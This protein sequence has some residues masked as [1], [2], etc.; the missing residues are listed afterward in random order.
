MPLYICGK[1]IDGKDATNE[2]TFVMIEE[3]KAL[4]I[5]DPKIHVLYH[6]NIDKKI[7]LKV[8][9]SIR[10]GKSSFV[11][12]NVEMAE[13]ALINVGIN[14][15]DAKKLIVYGCYELAAEGTEIPPTC[16]GR[17]CMPKA[18]E[19]ALYDGFDYQLNKQVGLHTGSYFDSF[20][21]FLTAVKTQLKN[22]IQYCMDALTAYEKEYNEISPF[23]ILSAAFENCV[24]TAKDVYDGGA[25]YNN[26]SIN[27]FGMA[28][29]VD[30]LMV[31]KKLIFEEKKLSFNEFSEILKSNWK[32][33]ETLRRYCIKNYPKFGNNNTEADE[34]AVDLYNEVADY[35]NRKPNGRGGV[36]KHS[37]ISI[38]WIKFM[39]ARV[40][41]TP[42]GRFEKQPV[43][44]NLCA[45]V[46]QDKN[47]ITG[48]INS[49]L[50]LDAKKS[51]N[52]YVLDAVLHSS[53]AKGEE[54]L[55]ALYSLL[56]TYI[57][58]GG[59]AIH[60]NILDSK[61]LRKAQI[62]PAEYKNLQIRLCGWNVRFVDLDKQ[63]QDEF[64]LKTDNALNN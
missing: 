58:N 23:P 54:G 57:K 18:L 15:E 47:G 48:F 8:L 25:K 9:D 62:N 28:T 42:D 38:D 43:S 11:F 26:T 24:K 20:D 56:N 6:K 53:A 30:S 63:T 44:K 13:K 52:G 5:I 4:D 16:A 40:G 64:I 50:K 14:E 10:D 49:V 55:N 35:I 21:E 33:N 37:Q 31:I 41:A 36:F 27:C 59:L 61:L 7:V 32:D 34:L 45:N 60:F 39:G 51:P 1:Y 3:Y 12:I 17:V 19:F 29:L 2:Y 46:G 22:A